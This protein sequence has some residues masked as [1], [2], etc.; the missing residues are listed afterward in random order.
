MDGV[1]H[2]VALENE[3]RAAAVHVLPYLAV[4]AFFV[5][6]QVD[7]AKLGVVGGIRVELA[8]VAEFGMVSIAAVRTAE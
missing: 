4:R 2:R 5:A 7:V 1:R 8:Q 6:A 3:Y